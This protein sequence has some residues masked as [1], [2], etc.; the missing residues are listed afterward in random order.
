MAIEA[1]SEVTDKANKVS[2][3]GSYV[4]RAIVD[5]VPLASEV[6]S[7][8]PQITCVELWGQSSIHVL[9]GGLSFLGDDF[10]FADH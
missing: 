5:N 4:L 8:N 7:K 6:G 2:S 3:D 9:P 1:E 10:L